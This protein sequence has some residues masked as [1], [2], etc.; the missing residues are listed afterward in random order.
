MLGHI[1]VDFCHYFRISWINLFEK[2]SVG[3]FPPSHDL[4]P[5]KLRLLY[6]M[7]FNVWSLPEDLLVRTVVAYLATEMHA[8]RGGSRFLARP[9]K[10]GALFLSVTKQLRT[11]GP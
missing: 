2:Y 1:T 4:N 5:Q 9:H 8:V 11:S 10:H 7:H 3:I 6:C